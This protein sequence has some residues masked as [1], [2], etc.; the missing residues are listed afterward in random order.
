MKLILEKNTLNKSKTV[1]SNN[2]KNAFQNFFLLRYHKLTRQKK[3]HYIYLEIFEVVYLMT[4]KK[5]NYHIVF[6]MI[7]LC[8]DSYL[9]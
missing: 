1:Y 2:N 3:K 6:V 9:S 5:I 7:L 8:S 4:S